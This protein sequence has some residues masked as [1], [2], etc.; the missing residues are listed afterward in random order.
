MRDK[1]YA[2]IRPGDEREIATVFR[3]WVET[4]EFE[5]YQIV[6]RHQKALHKSTIRGLGPIG[7]DALLA[8]IYL[9][10][11]EHNRQM[12]M[13]HDQWLSAF[14]AEMDKTCDTIREKEARSLHLA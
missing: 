13:K 5:E 4:L 3:E 9:L 6:T 12:P 10:W 2:G 1:L 7:A 11:L 14:D 8:V